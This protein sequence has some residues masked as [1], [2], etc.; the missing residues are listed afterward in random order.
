MNW[1]HRLA[2]LACLGALVLLPQTAWAWFIT[3]VELN[4]GGNARQRIDAGTPRATD[5]ADAANLRGYVLAVYDDL[6]V[7]ASI[8]ECFTGPL[9]AGQVMSIA[10]QYVTAHP[11]MWGQ[12]GTNLVQAALV[13]ACRKNRAKR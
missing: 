2:S 1:H 11:E 3:G 5:Y 9:V 6:D 13:E 4:E 12:P 8:S 7:E 10:S